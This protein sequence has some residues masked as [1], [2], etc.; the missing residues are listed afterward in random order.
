L[1]HNDD[2]DLT[3]DQLHWMRL[4]AQAQCGSRAAA[5]EMTALLAKLAAN[6]VHYPPESET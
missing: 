6:A 5:A 4:A 2:D 3:P 1:Y